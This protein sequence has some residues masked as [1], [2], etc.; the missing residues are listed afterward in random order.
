MRKRS[1]KYTNNVQAVRGIGAK[2][3]ANIDKDLETEYKR[4]DR[5][6]NGIVSSP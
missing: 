6:K 5:R 3:I 4:K 1:W 2:K